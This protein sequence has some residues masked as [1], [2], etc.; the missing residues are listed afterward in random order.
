MGE[1]NLQ[2]LHF[3]IFELFEG[4]I[5][6]ER[7]AILEK[8]LDG[9][10]A[11]RDYYFEVMKMYSF[12]N[13][14]RAEKA[15][16][17]KPDMD[18][19]QEINTDG[20]LKEV[21][22]KDLWE[23]ELRKWEL[24]AKQPPGPQAVENAF[25]RK[26]PSKITVL[27]FIGAIAAL[28]AMA[29]ILDYVQ[30]SQSTGIIANPSIAT[31]TDSTQAIWSIPRNVGD[32]LRNETLHLKQ[33]YAEITF[34]NNTR[35]VFEAPAEFRLETLDQF[36]LYNG[37]TTV[38]VA[39][40]TQGFKVG[41]PF[42]TIMDLGTEFGAYVTDKKSDV[43][44]FDGE[45]KLFVDAAL[46]VKKNR[47]AIITEGKAFQVR[48]DGA[49]I[50]SI[51][52]DKN[53]FVRKVPSEYDLTVKEYAPVLFWRINGQSP[54]IHDLAGVIQ[55]NSSEIDASV[56]ATGPP[57]DSSGEIYAAALDD[58]PLTIN[59]PLESASLFAEDYTASFWVYC[60]NPSH[61][62]DAKQPD[63]IEA[64]H[65]FDGS[66][67]FGHVLLQENKLVHFYLHSNKEGRNITVSAD[68][69]KYNRWRH[70][71]ITFNNRLKEKIFYI[72]GVRQD[73]D[74]NANPPITGCR[75]IIFS[76]MGE[77]VKINS[78]PFKGSISE[79]LL[80]DRALSARE[81]QTL[82]VRS[83]GK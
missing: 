37:K 56:L 29:V 73:A 39:E 49:G 2:E 28:V 6:N 61:M 27:K 33:G 53:I 13:D 77:N 9:S 35:A 62:K 41:T 71:V 1:I 69:M 23:A 58:A 11:A 82:Y 44:V 55:T 34:K 54:F 30:K 74:K 15:N 21:V 81:V 16:I 68:E 78:Y 4:A 5:S 57:V 47:Q 36:H 65:I 42:T 3:L 80:F 63:E 26:A 64:Y 38:H 79:T 40:G 59:L 72:D 24:A 52:Y 22:E 70:L 10:E 19:P 46:G 45:V 83:Q 60:E 20:A 51:Q 8:T 43:Y 18:N 76:G 66:G 48:N 17:L 14:P 50:R 32:S 75:K 25:V 31:L 12:L 67:R 7:L